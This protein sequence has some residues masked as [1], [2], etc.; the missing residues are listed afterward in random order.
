MCE[1][2]NLD[3]TFSCNWLLWLLVRR[4]RGFF[5]SEDLH[6]VTIA[7]HYE[8]ADSD[9]DIHVLCVL[10]S[11]GIDPVIK[12]NAMNALIRNLSQLTAW[13]P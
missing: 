12:L 7:V 3:E 8:R 6:F 9:C 11:N 5:K 4:R 2:L 13:L 10:E 1:L